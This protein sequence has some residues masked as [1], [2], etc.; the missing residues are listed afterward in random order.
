M[1]LVMY[2]VYSMLCAS[3]CTTVWK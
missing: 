1:Q 2:G 3:Q